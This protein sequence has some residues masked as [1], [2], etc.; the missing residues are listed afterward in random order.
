MTLIGHRV[1]AAIAV[2]ARDRKAKTKTHHGDAEARRKTKKY[3]GY[4]RMAADWKNGQ[5]LI[6]KYQRLIPYF[7]NNPLISA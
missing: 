2:I 4:L 3:H 6:T 1:I 5:R 7:L